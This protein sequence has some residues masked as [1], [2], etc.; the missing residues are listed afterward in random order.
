MAFNTYI[1]H[2]RRLTALIQQK[3]T[4]TPEL[5]AQRLKISRSKLFSLLKS[6]REDY[7]VPV[8]YDDERQ[9]YCFSREGKFFIGFLEK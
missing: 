8:F 5:L 4:G 9:S 3:A 2:L 7:N 6:L 1:N